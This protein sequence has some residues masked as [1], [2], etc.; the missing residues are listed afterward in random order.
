MD[1]N[2][3]VNI[4]NHLSD[5]RFSDIWDEAYLIVEPLTNEV[6]KKVKELAHTDIYIYSPPIVV[7]ENG[8]YKILNTIRFYVLIQDYKIKINIIKESASHDY[9]ETLSKLELFDLPF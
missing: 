7:K 3:A 4:L 8:F 6:R 5:S 1:L 9:N 2:N